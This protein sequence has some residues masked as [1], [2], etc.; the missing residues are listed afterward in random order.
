MSPIPKS[1]STAQ[2]FPYLKLGA[3]LLFT[4]LAGI[5][6][7]MLIEGFSFIEA[8]YMTVITLSTVGFGEVRNLGP[9]GRLFVILMIIGGLGLVTYILS[10][11]AG[12]VVEGRFRKLLG[13]RQMKKEIDRLDR[14]YV[15]C[16]HGRM[17]EIVCR[18]LRAEG[19]SYVVVESDQEAVERLAEA[20]H[21]V[22][23]GD[24]TEDEVLLAAGITRARALVAV[25]SS[26]VDNLYITLTARE[27]ARSGNPG[28]Y[29]MARATNEKASAK[30]RHAGA[31]RV[32]SPY[33]IGGNHLVNALLRPHVHDFIEVLSQG[34]DMRL[35]V[36]ELPVREGCSFAGMPIRDSNLRQQ[37]D[38]IIIGLLKEGERMVFN[39][40]PDDLLEAGDLLIVLGPQNQVARLADRMGV[41]P[42]G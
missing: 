30:I 2:G 10:A 34:E 9:G 14:H 4:V 20:G 12:F 22:V 38:L 42:A 39:P 31:D 17:G 5:C 23:E 33:L 40:G 3:L 24:A 29:V 16:G 32:I 7:L 36:E 13:R 1:D 8:L 25:V 26:D 6:G 37:Y 18:A 28:L 41:D 35:R 21:L 15:I 11:L 19:R 27:L